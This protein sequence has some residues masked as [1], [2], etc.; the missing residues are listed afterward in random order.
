MATHRHEDGSK[1][2]VL[3]CFGGHNPTPLPVLTWPN[4]G[5]RALGVLFISL[6]K[7][8][9]PKKSLTS[10]PTHVGAPCVLGSCIQPSWALRPVAPS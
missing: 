10:K 6:A 4:W 7:G 3:G 8:T 1:L 9:N 2:G 5:C